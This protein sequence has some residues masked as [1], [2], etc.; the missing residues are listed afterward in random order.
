MSMI[1]ILTLNNEVKKNI[2]NHRYSLEEMEGIKASISETVNTK[3]K[4]LPLLFTV[5]VAIISIVSILGFIKGGINKVMIYFILMM[6]VIVVASMGFAWFVCVGSLKS[7]YNRAV[8]KGYP[9]YIDRLL[10]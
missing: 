2:K 7:Q 9:E 4:G 1:Y 8:K 10:V 3:K 5:I 6:I